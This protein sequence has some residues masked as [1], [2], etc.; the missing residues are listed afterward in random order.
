M[1]EI[2]KPKR[3]SD[4]V[5][6][7][8]RLEWLR[9]QSGLTGTQFGELIGNDQS[10][11]SKIKNSK[12][13]LPK[14]WAFAAV[15]RFGITMD[16]LYHGSTKGLDRRWLDQLLSTPEGLALIEPDDT[17]LRTGSTQP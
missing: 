12:R 2:R 8:A 4:P 6:V 13:G 9:L 5:R 1:N 10:A 15:N 16:F 14:T 11:Y 3:T 7:A 17:G